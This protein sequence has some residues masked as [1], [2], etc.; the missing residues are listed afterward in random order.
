[1]PLLIRVRLHDLPCRRIERSVDVRVDRDTGRNRRS[2]DTKR[3]LA[4]VREA[5]R[6]HDD[7][8]LGLIEDAV[9]RHAAVSERLRSGAVRSANRERVDPE[10]GRVKVLERHT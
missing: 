7:V 8:T 5:R 3:D 1:M 10:L 2:W 9:V 4:L 6:L